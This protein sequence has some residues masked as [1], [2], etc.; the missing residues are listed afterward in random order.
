MRLLMKP[1]RLLL[2]LRILSN[3]GQLL[4]LCILTL[5][6]LHLDLL[7]SVFKKHSVFLDAFFW[8]DYDAFLR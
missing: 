2:F 5:L 8:L 7:L 1:V 4:L 6:L 3:Y